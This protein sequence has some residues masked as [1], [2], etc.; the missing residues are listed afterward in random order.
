[1]T[2][3]GFP[4]MTPMELVSAE[5]LDSLRAPSPTP[6]PYFFP[7]CLP[8]FWWCD[9]TGCE[10]PRVSTSVIKPTAIKVWVLSFLYEKGRGRTW[11]SVSGSRAATEGLR[12]HCQCRG[13]LRQKRG[14]WC[15]ASLR[16][17]RWAHWTSFVVIF[18]IL[19]L[20]ASPECGLAEA[21]CSRPPEGGK[22][23]PWW[24]GLS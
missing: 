3:Q 16:C 1:M 9:W 13:G 22:C 17:R 24:T 20:G 19:I 12:S 7:M 11:L 23:V 21:K 4:A 6:K 18:E 14:I 8:L 15:E 2:H 5:C 10:R